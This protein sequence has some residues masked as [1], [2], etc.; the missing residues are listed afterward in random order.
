VHGYVESENFILAGTDI[1]SSRN[2]Y[3]INKVETHAKIDTRFGTDDFHARG[4]VHGYV[5]PYETSDITNRFDVKELYVRSRF[6]LLDIKVGRQ[7]IRWGTT[8]AV[9]PV[10]YF[11]PQDFSEFLFK[12]EDEIYMGVDAISV[13][14]IIA[15]YSIELVCVPV[16]GVTRMPSTGSAWAMKDF[17]QSTIPVTYQHTAPSFPATGKNVSYGG[18]V[19]GSD[20]GMDFAISGFY[21]IDPVVLMLPYLQSTV[22]T[23]IINTP[24]YNRVAQFGFDFAMA[25][26]K[27]TI[28]VEGI[29]SYNKAGVAASDPLVTGQLFV[30][31]KTHY[32][33][34][35]GGVNWM[36]DGE[37]FNVTVEFFQGYY[38]K[39]RDKFQPPYISD[40]VVAKIEKRFFNGTLITEIKGLFNVFDYDWALMP[41]V[42]Y[43]F[44][45]GFKVEVEAAV[46]EGKKETTVGNFSPMDLVRIRAR[47]EF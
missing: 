46:I 8:D 5:Y 45:N 43:D 36:I 34:Y 11:S 18:R 39:D 30:I 23:T 37:N 21:G 6:S 44:Q 26:D 40:M 29:Y 22:P 14:I 15:E 17:T 32:V 33:G 35:A 10:S 3:R 19:S 25:V 27:F 42:C 28:Q 38:L 47:Y 16:P 13:K 24:Q 4:V 7:F 31:E 20:K 9:N 2:E 41:R 12:D 1:K